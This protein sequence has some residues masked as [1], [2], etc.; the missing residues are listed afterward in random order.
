MASTTLNSPDLTHGIHFTHS[1]D[2]SKRT[3]RERLSQSAIDG[4]ISIADR[5]SLTIDERCGL[6]GVE[7]STLHR[8]RT[9][10]GTRS[11]DE[12]TRVSYIVGMYK[13]LHL[14]FPADL[15][16]E[17]VKRPNINLLFGGSRPLDFLLR[18]G[19]PGFHQVRS[20]LDGYRGGL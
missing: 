6:L 3:T 10:A 12:L 18:T 8:L 9:G 1:P 19:I 14:L 4:F 11:Q 5:W 17:W 13:A 7:R 20:L 15:A 2:L 16:N